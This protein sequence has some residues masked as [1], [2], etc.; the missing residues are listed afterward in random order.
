MQFFGLKHAHA[1]LLAHILLLI[2]ETFIKW[3]QCASLR[4]GWVIL[5]PSLPLTVPG[6]PDTASWIS[7]QLVDMSQKTSALSIGIFSIDN[8]G[9]K[10]IL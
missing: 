2:Q 5:P 4:S 6:G 9:Y 1:L 3:P 7:E 8:A 10:S